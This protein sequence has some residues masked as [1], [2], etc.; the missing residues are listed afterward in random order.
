M[1]GSLESS[2]RNS[3][4]WA[5]ELEQQHNQFMCALAGLPET[6]RVVI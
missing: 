6:Y 1:G 4:N 2:S 3:S 5:A